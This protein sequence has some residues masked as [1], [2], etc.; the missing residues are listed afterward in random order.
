MGIYG[1]GLLYE[2]CLDICF[3]IC[4][5]GLLYEECL[6]ICYEIIIPGS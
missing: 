3:E 2:E 5:M 4:G 1:M 6:D